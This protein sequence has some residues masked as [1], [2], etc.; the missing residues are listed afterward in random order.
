ME[1]HRMERVMEIELDPESYFNCARAA[2]LF[3]FLRHT[4]MTLILQSSSVLMCLSGYRGTHIEDEPA[5]EAGLE[6]SVNS[7][8]H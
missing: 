5:P 4:T 6:T 3:L 1:F 2:L 8:I 7:K